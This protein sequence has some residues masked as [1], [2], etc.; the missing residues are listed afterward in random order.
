MAYEQWEVVVVPFPFVNSLKS[1][2][3]PV[4]ILSNGSFNL[5]TGHYIAAMITSSSL[6]P[7][8]GDTEIKD[9]A[10]IGLNKPSF[11]RLKLFTMDER[12]VKRK[13]G[14]LSKPDIENVKQSLASYISM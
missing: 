5:Q 11:V 13:I 2:P 10:G 3:R 8:A 14:K 4:L 12:L 9:F 6:N 7:W 1:K